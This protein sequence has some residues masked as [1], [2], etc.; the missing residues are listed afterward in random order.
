MEEASVEAEEAVIQEM[1][2]VG[3]PKAVIVVVAAVD[4]VDVEDVEDVEKAVAGDQRFSMLKM[5]PLLLLEKME[6]GQKETLK[7]PSSLV[8]FHTS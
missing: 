6:P 4:V 7:L 3:L 2:A 5:L 8:I 1:T